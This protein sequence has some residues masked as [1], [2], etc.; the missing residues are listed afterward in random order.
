MELYVASC[1]LHT[2]STQHQTEADF[3]TNVCTKHTIHGECKKSRDNFN[4]ELGAK[5]RRQSSLH[6]NI[7]IDASIAWCRRRGELVSEWVSEWEGECTRY[8]HNI[9]S[10]LSQCD[11]FE[12]L[13]VCFCCVCFFCFLFSVPSTASSMRTIKIYRSV[14]RCTHCRFTRKRFQLIPVRV[15]S[16]VCTVRPCCRQ[17]E[18][19]SFWHSR[20][21]SSGFASRI[22]AYFFLVCYLPV[23]RRVAMSVQTIL[24]DFSIEPSR[25]SDAESRKDL[26]KLLENGLTE[27]FPQLK[28]CYELTTADGHLVLFTENQSLFF[29]VRLF[30]HGIITINAEYF[31]SDADPQIISFDVSRRPWISPFSTPDI[32]TYIRIGAVVVFLLYCVWIF[33]CRDSIRFGMQKNVEH[34]FSGANRNI[35]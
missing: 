32:Y 8:R 33:G 15:N 31:K 2:F 23:Q 30:N 29:H 4:N 13:S 7:N 14:S 22:N 3:T 11:Y 9:R 35:F 21:Y 27:H 20:S 17:R 24:L 26:V 5:E 34:F 6:T 18:K 1:T 19:F 10:T 25:I 12:V 16:Q 28:L